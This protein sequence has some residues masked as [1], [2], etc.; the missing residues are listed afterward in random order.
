M[1]RDYGLGPRQR[2]ERV[3]QRAARIEITSS[4]HRRIAEG[5]THPRN[6]TNYFFFPVVFGFT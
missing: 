6:L 4:A 5:E 1:G 2:I 3:A